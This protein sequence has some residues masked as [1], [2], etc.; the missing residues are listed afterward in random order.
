MRSFFASTFIILAS[1]LC[2]AGTATAL[3]VLQTPAKTVN[4]SEEPLLSHT[5]VHGGYLE[6]GALRQVTETIRV[7]RDN[8]RMLVDLSKGVE[9]EGNV[10]TSH[11]KALDVRYAILSAV[12]NSLLKATTPQEVQEASAIALAIIA[13]KT[14]LDA[15]VL[16]T[17]MQ[18]MNAT[19]M[20]NG[21]T[22]ACSG[23]RILTVEEKCEQPVIS[24]QSMQPFMR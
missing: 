3:S 14:D 16:A 19:R 13:I 23:N 7:N 11:I 22:S 18:I 10:F 24:D 15:A 17:Q 1:S 5:S 8:R 4:P 6:K 9:G 12:G 2:L 21:Y 20:S